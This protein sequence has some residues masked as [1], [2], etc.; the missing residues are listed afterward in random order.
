[1]CMCK[2]SVCIC[3]WF[4]FYFEWISSFGITYINAR[5]SCTFC[6]YSFGYMWVSEWTW[7]GGVKVVAIGC[8]SGSQK[9]LL[10][11]IYDYF[12]A[13]LQQQRQQKQPE[14]SSQVYQKVPQPIWMLSILMIQS[15][16]RAKTIDTNSFRSQIAS[17][18]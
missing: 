3:I 9:S 13:K 12:I 14:I 18:H 17:N 10:A 1:M 7:T 15:D 8:V 4:D 5:V 16:S 11:F 2:Y 6:S